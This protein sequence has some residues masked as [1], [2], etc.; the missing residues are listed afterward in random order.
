MSLWLGCLELDP[1]T[2]SW[3]YFFTGILWSY[4]NLF[5]TCQKGCFVL[6]RQRWHLCQIPHFSPP[7]L[8]PSLSFFLWSRTWCVCSQGWSSKSGS[9]S[10]TTWV[11]GLRV[12]VTLPCT[13]LGFC[14][15]GQGLEGNHENQIR[16]SLLSLPWIQSPSWRE[17]F[18]H[19][20]HLAFH[21]LKAL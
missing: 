8:P 14:V 19:R 1:L 21:L 9:S 2:C 5:V 18:H 7:S 12:W 16:V 11:L 17:W 10:P 13:I 4:E 15:C 20:K 6:V 3:L